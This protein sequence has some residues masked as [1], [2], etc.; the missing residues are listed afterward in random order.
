MELKL[1]T[2]FVYRVLDGGVAKRVGLEV[3]QVVHM[4]NGVKI[5]SSQCE[6]IQS[7]IRQW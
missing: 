7:L 3:G 1:S 5:I 4:I 6:E 2:T